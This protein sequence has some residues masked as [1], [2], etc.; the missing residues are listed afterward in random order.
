[1]GLFAPAVG[2]FQYP[3]NMNE[4]LLNTLNELPFEN[5]KEY[6]IKLTAVSANSNGKVN[7]AM[8][9]YKSGK[10][11]VTRKWEKDFVSSKLISIKE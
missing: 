9:N 11:Y 1:M 2:I 8:C 6:G 10:Y 5:W 4:T 3:T 7:S